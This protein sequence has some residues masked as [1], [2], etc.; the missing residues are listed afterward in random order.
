MS[1]PST[2]VGKEQMIL[3]FG[4]YISPEIRITQVLREGLAGKLMLTSKESIG[5][6][7][8][9]SKLESDDKAREE[10]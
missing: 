5:I 2:R 8:N 10:A 1:V 4:P 7:P 9:Y 6:A 3:V